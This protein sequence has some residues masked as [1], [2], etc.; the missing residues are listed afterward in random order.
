MSK[1]SSIHHLREETRLRNQLLHQIRNIFLALR[2]ECLLIPR[3]A[4][5][6]D[7]DNFSVFLGHTGAGE[8][9]GGQQSA[10]EGEAGSVAK[11]LAAVPRK[12]PHDRV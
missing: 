2:R 3:A 8:Q 9:H 6:R 7:D 12:L 10:A 4:T 1:N 5:E 11:E